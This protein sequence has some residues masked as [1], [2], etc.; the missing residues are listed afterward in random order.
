MIFATL[1]DRGLVSRLYKEFLQI[2][3]SENGEDN[4][5]TFYRKVNMNG[6]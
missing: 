4:E 3:K 6:S 5:Q 1:V 2:N